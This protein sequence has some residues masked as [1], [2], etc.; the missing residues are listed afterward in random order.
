MVDVGVDALRVGVE[1]C[2]TF[3]RFSGRLFDFVSVPP[4]VLGV[5]ITGLAGL[6]GDDACCFTVDSL[7]FRAGS[8]RRAG[9]ASAIF[10]ISVGMHLVHDESLRMVYGVFGLKIANSMVQMETTNILQVQPDAK[11]SPEQGGKRSTSLPMCIIL[12]QIA[13]CTRPFHLQRLTYCDTYLTCT[14]ESVP[15]SLRRSAEVGEM[16]Q[17]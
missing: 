13:L 12:S 1:T 10:R 7:R 8:T 6:R 3:A 16:A 9:V 17:R 2:T 11:R 4:A 15:A 5:T 14:I